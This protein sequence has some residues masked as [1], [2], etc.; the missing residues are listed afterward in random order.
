MRHFIDRRLNPKDKSRGNRQRF[1]RRARAQ[2]KK[3]VNESL[4]DRAIT[5]VGTNEKVSIPSKGIREPRFR[6]NP[7]GGKREG[8]Y[9]GNRE[10][11]PGDR[12]ARP[13]TGAGAGGKK[14]S[15]QGEGEDDFTF[16]LSREEFLDLFFEDLELP[17]L[18]KTNLK[19]VTAFKPRRAGYTTSGTIS[20]LNILRTMR[21]SYGRRLALRR[22]VLGNIDTLRKELDTLCA[23]D[24][25]SADDQR[26]LVEIEAT[27]TDLERRWRLI[28]YIDPMDVRYNRFEPQPQPKTSAVMFCLMDVSGSM[29]QHEKDLAKRFYVLL[30]LFLK[31]RYERIDMVFIRHTHQAQEVDEET[32]F[33]SRETGGTVVSTA[34]V[35]MK[36]VISDRYP[37]KDWNIYAAQASDG[38]NMESDMGSCLAL[39]TGGLLPL[40]QHFAYIEILDEQELLRFTSSGGGKTLWRGYQG[41]GGEWPNFAMKQISKPSDIYPVFHELFAKQSQKG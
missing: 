2:I 10:F 28:P 12:I 34:L 40:C 23:L 35:E 21:N 37:A 22:P 7:S 26:R 14:A 11:T 5:D 27:L 31:R 30:H 32:F 25:P 36:K 3:A 9:P 38:D 29:G 19:D 18:V 15:D 41:L 13:P 4:Q 6:M 17:D 20:N 39:L 8:T 1:L 24:N 33:R 16:D